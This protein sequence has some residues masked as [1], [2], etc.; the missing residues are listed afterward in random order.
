MRP[1]PSLKC[2]W[3]TDSS[4]SSNCCTSA[5]D[6]LASDA[7]ASCCAEMG[8]MNRAMSSMSIG[9]ADAMMSCCDAACV[10]VAMVD[11]N[12]ALMAPCCCCVARASSVTMDS[13]RRADSASMA[14]RFCNAAHLTSRARLEGAEPV[15]LRVCQAMPPPAVDCAPAEKR[16]C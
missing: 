1:S 15:V 4:A 14:P 9:P 3:R 13:M 10:S 12:A 2:C 5:R 8:L 6:G 16:A 7:T 11:S